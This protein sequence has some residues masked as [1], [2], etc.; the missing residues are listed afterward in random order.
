MKLSIATTALLLTA[1]FMVEDTLAITKHRGTRRG[2]VERLLS[3]SSKAPSSSGKGKGKQEGETPDPDYFALAMR[4]GYGKSFGEVTCLTYVDGTGFPLELTEGGYSEA[5]D[6]SIGTRCCN[7][8]TIAASTRLWTYL[9]AEDKPYFRIQNKD[10]GKCLQFPSTC[11]TD[12]STA[13]IKATA[14]DTDSRL[15]LFR[16][17]GDKLVGK[18]CFTAFAVTKGLGARGCTDGVIDMK[19]SSTFPVNDPT[20]IAGKCERS[21]CSVGLCST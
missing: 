21:V 16:E 14:C 4:C 1:L 3:K 15:Q 11:G 12:P 18:S 6:R 10:S 8:P 5:F 19:A 2:E 9:S 7:D 20:N 13:G 17:S